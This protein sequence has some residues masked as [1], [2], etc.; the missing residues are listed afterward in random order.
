MS[1]TTPA[2][3]ARAHHGSRSLDLTIPAKLCQEMGIHEGDLFLV[4]V[5]KDREGQ[6][7]LTYTRV[8]PR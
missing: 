2:V 5:A 6:I 1:Q 3:R 7:I 4:K 8:F